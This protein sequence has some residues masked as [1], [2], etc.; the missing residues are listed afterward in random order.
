LDEVE[1]VMDAIGLAD[2]HVF[3]HTDGRVTALRQ[4]TTNLFLVIA[5]SPGYVE[6]R[7]Y[8]DVHGMILEEVSTSPITLL[9]PE[10]SRHFG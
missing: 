6:F 1:V 4:T 7:K 2:W 3:K 5:K 10:L 9:S 8:A